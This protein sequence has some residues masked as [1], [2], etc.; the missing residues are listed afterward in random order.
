L[1]KSIAL[2]SLYYRLILVV[3]KII[4]NIYNQPIPIPILIANDLVSIVILS[5][6]LLTSRTI[7]RPRR[8]VLSISLPSPVAPKILPSLPTLLLLRLRLPPPRLPT[9]PWYTSVV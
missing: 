8:L 7:L 1:T 4:R 3:L 2:E 9:P 6:L 5:P